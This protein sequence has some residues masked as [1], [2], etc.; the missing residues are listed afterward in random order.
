MKSEGNTIRKYILPTNNI[1]ILGIPD[2]LGV[3]KYAIKKY[4]V[5]NKMWH[6]FRHL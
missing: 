6:T 3:E 2:F 5:Q 1:Y 4:S